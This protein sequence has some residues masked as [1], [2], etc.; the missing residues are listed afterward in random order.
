MEQ[1]IGPR[2]GP[3]RRSGQ[4]R[5]LRSTDALLGDRISPGDATHNGVGP[6]L[7]IRKDPSFRPHPPLPYIRY[8]II[9]NDEWRPECG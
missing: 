9:S 6:T 8:P 1:A 3:G 5:R 2:T 4:S 7:A